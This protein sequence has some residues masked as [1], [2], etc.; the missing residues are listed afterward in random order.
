MAFCH[1]VDMERQ[2]IANVEQHRANFANY[3]SDFFRNHEDGIPSLG[4]SDDGEGIIFR[5]KAWNV[6]DNNNGCFFTTQ[7]GRIGCGAHWMKPG[8]M[9]CILFGGTVP[10]ILR[11]EKFKKD[12][13]ILIGDAY[14]D[15]MMEGE[16]MEAFDKGELDP[17]VQETMFRIK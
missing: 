3:L 11:R 1:G 15:G 17:S 16:L 12:D 4:G 5:N 10:Y 2:K 9:V 13:H 7:A 14:V 6:F 8:D